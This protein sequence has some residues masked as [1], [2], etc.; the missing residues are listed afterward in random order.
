[1]A[2]EITI[3]LVLY[4]DEKYL[5]GLA[6]SL[7]AQTFSNFSVI[8]LDNRGSDASGKLFKE[9]FPEEEIIRAPYNLGFAGG[10]NLLLDA[11]LKRN[12]QFVLIM[13][14]D[15]ELHPDFLKNLYF[16]ADIFP[17]VDA[18]G[19]VVCNG[20]N[21][22][23]SNVIQNY[24]LFMDF[25]MAKKQSPDAGKLVH[26]IE[27]LPGT[28]EVDY[29]SGVALMFRSK[30]LEEMPL[31]DENLFLYGE[32]RDFFCR[33]RRAGHLAL[34][35]RNAVCWHFHDWSPGN[36]SGYQRE[37]YYLRRNKVLY[38]RKYHFTYG[39]ICFLLTEL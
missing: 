35:V 11:A 12:P 9:L 32:E 36:A 23:R 31:W 13:N 14:T 28:I 27:G 7:R 39:L 34:V 15:V 8:A 25:P 2:P 29:L 21:G 6:T 5:P 30:V 4:N 1:M 33:F 37:Y 38:F 22:K 20:T 3:Q 18:F 26:N 19:P 17:A 10:H 24:R 16:Q